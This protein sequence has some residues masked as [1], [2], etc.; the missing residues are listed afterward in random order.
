MMVFQHVA[1]MMMMMIG[2]T[3][4]FYLPGVV[5]RQFLPDELVPVKVNSLKSVRTHL[6]Y[7]YY[8]LPFCRPAEIKKMYENLGEILAG[9]EIENSPYEL[10]MD[11]FETCKVLCRKSYNSKEVKQFKEKIDE[12]YSVNWVV[13]NLPAAT[14]VELPGYQ[15]QVVYEH[16][17]YLGGH[18]YKE[19]ASKLDA[20]LSSEDINAEVEAWY[21]NNHISIKIKTHSDAAYQG[22]RVVQVEVEPKSILHSHNDWKEGEEQP[23]HMTVETECVDP[24]QMLRPAMIIDGNGV[25]KNADGDVVVVWTYDVAWEPSDIHWASR[26]DIYLSMNDKYDDEFHWFGIINSLLMIF[27]LTGIIAL[28]MIRTLKKDVSFYNRVLTEEERLEEKDESGWKLLHGD[29]FRSPPLVMLFSV[30]V[31]NATQIFGMS[32]TTLVFAAL[33]FLSPANRGSLMIALIVLFVLM[34]APA[35]FAAART[36]KNL[37][38]TQWQK[39]ILLTA[40]GFPFLI[41]CV[42]FVV[43]LAV[44]YEGS[45]SAVRSIV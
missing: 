44:W 32:C 4:G 29:V 30:L 36:Y 39:T 31:G 40:L 27:L 33:G 17:Y 28:I 7:S 14:V 42:F 19:G 34:G 23:T 5:P 1:M 11:R 10:Y 3:R 45:T 13:D 22:K 18:Q 21:L 8:D 12:E 2:I 24:V 25:Q 16:G 26:W 20:A 35:G 43:N 15:E 6:P 9:D 38:G 41:F 37:G